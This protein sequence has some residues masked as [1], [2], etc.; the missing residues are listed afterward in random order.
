MDFFK[1]VIRCRNSTNEYL[2]LHDDSLKDLNTLD[3]L[4]LD[5]AEGDIAQAKQFSESLNVDPSY[6]TRRIGALEKSGLIFR[7]K[8]GREKK[9]RLTDRGREVTSL[10]FSEKKLLYR[11]V[12]KEVSPDELETAMKVLK[13][14][15]TVMIPRG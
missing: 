1:E 12:L 5:S 10:I 6:I 13:T 4:L 2:K 8:K 9:V 15:N 11:E 7:M 14:I 3:V